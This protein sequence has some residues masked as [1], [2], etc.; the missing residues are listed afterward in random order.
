MADIR[1]GEGSD[2]EVDPNQNPASGDQD[3]SASTQSDQNRI[4][5]EVGKVSLRILDNSK[6]LL[7]KM[8]RF[9]S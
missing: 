8:I 6:F 2:G 4:G 9:L 7:L 3:T 5:Q 1:T